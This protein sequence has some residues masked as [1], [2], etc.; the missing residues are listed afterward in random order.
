M[1]HKTIADSL[2]HRRPTIAR[3]CRRN[4]IFAGWEPI[5]CSFVASGLNHPMGETDEEALLYSGGFGG[6]FI[7]I[8]IRRQ[9]RAVASPPS[10]PSPLAL[11]RQMA[12]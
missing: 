8:A 12:P 5:G 11:I 4:S 7:R 10:S 6:R 3:S 9:R 1:N 2:Q